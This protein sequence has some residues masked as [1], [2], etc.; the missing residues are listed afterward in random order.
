[1]SMLGMGGGQVE[2]AT[3]LARGRAM[4]QGLKRRSLC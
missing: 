1:M 2:R 3:I 4:L